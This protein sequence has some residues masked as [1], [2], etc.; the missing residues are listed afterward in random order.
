VSRPSSTELRFT[1]QGAAVPG[2]AEVVA[3]DKARSLRIG[4]IVYAKPRDP[5]L[6]RVVGFGASLTMGVQSSSIALHGQVH[7]PAAQFAKA[8]GAYLSMPL[9][10]DEYMPG[11]TASDFDLATC[12]PKF[13]DLEQLMT[14][15][16]LTNVLPKV[17]DPDKGIVIARI[18]VDPEV[19]VRNVA[20]GGFKIHD[21]VHGPGQ[22]P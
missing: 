17:T 12:Q 18:R 13:A 6:F 10:R 19:E 16:G 1:V 5:A 21:V 22:F 14:E 7:G 9:V 20:I 11:L 3:W 2:P 4:E 15:R 8:A